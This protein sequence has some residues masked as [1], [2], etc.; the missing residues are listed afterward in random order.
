ML[1]SALFESIAHEDIHR[2][3]A[4]IVPPNPAS[5]AL[6]RRFGFAP[7]GTLSQVGRKFGRY[8][9][10]LRMERPL[11]EAVSPVVG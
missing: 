8:W 10:V 2:I 4:A 5:I 11:Q 9:G 7:V 1:Y 3:V 6:H